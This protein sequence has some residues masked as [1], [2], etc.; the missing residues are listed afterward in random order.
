MTKITHSLQIKIFCNLDLKGLISKNIVSLVV[1]SLRHFQ[2]HLGG[3]RCVYLPGQLT[4]TQYLLCGQVADGN[5]PVERD[6]M[7]LTHREHLD[8]LHHY[9]L[10]VVLIK[11]SIVQN[12]C[13]QSPDY[14]SSPEPSP[15]S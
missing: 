8:V 7:V 12:L 3:S 9:H 1:H 13:G 4:E 5:F 11:H 2:Y 15:F 10:V 6:E 14:S